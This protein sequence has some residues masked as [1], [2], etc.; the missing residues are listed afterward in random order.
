MPDTVTGLGA[1]WQRVSCLGRIQFS[2]MRLPGCLLIEAAVASMLVAGGSLIGA[3]A[4][5][6]IRSAVSTHR[7]SPPRAPAAKRLGLRPRQDL[8]GDSSGDVMIDSPGTFLGM[9]DDLLLDRM[10]TQ[11]VTRIKLNHGGSSLSFR[12]DFADGSRAA[13]KPAQT[14]AQTVPRKEVA[15]Y[16]LN[17]LLGLN[18]VPPAASRAITREDLFGLLHPD[19]MPA[20]PR[21]RSETIIGPSGMIAGEASYWIPVIKDCE[22]DTPDGHLEMIGWLT[23]G[24]PVPFQYR[25]LAA[26]VAV[27]VVFD[28][29]IANPDRRSGG[30]MKTSEDG[31][32]LFFMDN[33][34]SFFLDPEGTEKNRQVFLKSQR[35]SRGLNLA[36]GRVEIPTLR[37]LMRE[38]DGTDVLT[39][40]E[41]RAV[42]RRREFVQRTVASLIKQYG[43]RNVLWFP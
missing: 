6:E 13:W 40:A 16:R 19:S 34:M 32:Q 9:S 33:T 11:S 3:R 14:N 24:E 41:I 29:L 36:L 8:S 27:M 39:E 35:F 18:A 30:N 42:V 37:R 26:Q 22:F 1:I 28:F 12:I 7:A 4:L 2:A 25:S 15:A 17:R 23:Q 5:I 21:I 43:E 20:L 38:P 31:S 10:R